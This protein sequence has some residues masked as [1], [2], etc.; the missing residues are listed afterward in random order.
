MQAIFTLMFSQVII[1]ILGLA[2]KLYLTN[3]EGFGDSGNAISS[4]GF[5]IYAILL[6]ISSIGV[7]N[8]VAKLISERISIGDEKGANKIF[9]VAFAT[10]SIVGFLSAVFLFCS[11]NFLANYV[12]QIP[13]AELTLMVLAPSIF[14]EALI[15]VYKGYFNGY[16]N[17]KPMAASQ[18]IEQLSKTTLTIF[19]VEIICYIFGNS[20][21][22]TFLMSAGAN[23]ATTI[24]TFVGFC[25]LTKI[26]L[27]MERNIH[28]TRSKTLRGK[29]I[30]ISI[31]VIAMPMTITAFLGSLNKNIDA[32]TVVRE[33]KNF[34]SEEQAQ[35]QYGILSGKVETLVMLPLSFNIAL[36]VTLIP[37]IS[38][39]MASGNMQEVKRR[40]SFSL[41]ITMLIALPC[42]IGMLLYAK[43]I[44][45]LLFPN[46]SSGAI[47]LQISCI[48][49]I[50][51]TIEQTI[52][53]ALQGIGKVY[54]PIISL[55]CG[56]IVKLIMNIIFVKINP[57]NFF[58]GGIN[59]AALGTLISHI[60]STI[61]SILILRKY[62]KF[63]FNISKFIVK[64]IVAV[65]F[66]S[67]ISYTI[68][69][70]MNSI[71][72]SKITTIIAIIVAG[73]TYVISVFALRIFNKNE[74]GMVQILKKTSKNE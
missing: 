10:F 4:S 48:S 6:T 12:L 47:L 28:N 32:I 40:I 57:T 1:K 39:A 54:V 27:K 58:F 74:L 5:Q 70:K 72:S 25:Y 38:A 16:Q 8:A 14:F 26:Y 20:R 65:I 55:L 24:A 52:M 9:K 62:I 60:T 11:A 18:A 61:I 23:F 67:V 56:V 64:P 44:L 53:G 50:F 73:A 35:I 68:F 36:S 71:I 30:L 13:E 41:L 34:L 51:I 17:M 29:N 7:P 31:I 2:Y 49:I 63:E 15:S 3:K 37:A 43:P 21:Q 59:G 69:I 45:E 46:A 42:S 19:L 66:M 33:L 22:I